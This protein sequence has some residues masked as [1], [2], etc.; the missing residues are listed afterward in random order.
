MANSPHLPSGNLHELR[1]GLTTERG[2]ARLRAVPPEP[3]INHEEPGPAPITQIGPRKLVRPKLT[4]SMQRKRTFE[5]RAESPILAH[6]SPAAV[7]RADYSASSAEAFYFQKQV[8]TQTV[9]V[10]VL[11]DGEQVEGIIEWYDRDAIKIRNG[12]R[13]LIY[14]S[15]I[16]YLYKAG[17]T[18]GV[19]N[20]FAT[21]R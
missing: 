16:K 4:E 17:D 2:N 5:P 12:K 3:A 6:Q 10:F 8:Q 19:L 21:A 13:T 15:A 18:P 1:P 7:S 11:E 14:K 20:G 9:M